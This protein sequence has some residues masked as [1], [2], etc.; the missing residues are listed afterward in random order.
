LE[1]GKS[2]LLFVVEM[3]IILTPPSA[4][5]N[6]PLARYKTLHLHRLAFLQILKEYDA[7]K[8]CEFWALCDLDTKTRLECRAVLKKMNI[9][10]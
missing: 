4:K 3:I 10:D 5:L 9:K 8:N 2:P 1:L 6:I 7:I